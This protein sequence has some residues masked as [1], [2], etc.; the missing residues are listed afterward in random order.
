M[1]GDL[2]H[3]TRSGGEAIGRALFDDLTRHPLARR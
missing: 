2:V 3:F 1:R